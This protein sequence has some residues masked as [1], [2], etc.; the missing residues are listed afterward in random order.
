MTLPA[1]A[2]TGPAPGAVR[3]SVFDALGRVVAASEP[4]AG[5]GRQRLAVPTAGLASGVYAVRVSGPG[6]EAV[7]RLAVVR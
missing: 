6:V 2:G 5:A 1:F 7:R 3:L 4:L